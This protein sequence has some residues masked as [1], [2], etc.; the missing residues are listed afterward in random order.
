MDRNIEN[1]VP[2]FR[3]Y[4]TENGYDREPRMEKSLGNLLTYMIGL[5]R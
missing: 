1:N 4:L 3:S 5:R 2:D